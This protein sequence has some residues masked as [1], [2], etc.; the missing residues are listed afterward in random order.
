VPVLEGVAHRYPDMRILVPHSGAALAFFSDR[1][2][3]FRQGRSGPPW[4]DAMR[5][6]WFDTAGRTPFPIQLPVLADVAGTAYIVYGSD[7][8]WTPAAGVDA[9]LASIDAAPPTQITKGDLRTGLVTSTSPPRRRTTRLDQPRILGQ[10]EHLAAPDPQR[11]PR[12]SKG[13]RKYHRYH[14]SPGRAGVALD[15]ARARPAHTQSRGR[16]Q[17]AGMSVAWQR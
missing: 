5:T 3:L 6:L 2:E 10:R 13:P 15:A 4:R 14:S 16:L 12:H 11:V 1:I 9:Q 7:S 17:L 8:C